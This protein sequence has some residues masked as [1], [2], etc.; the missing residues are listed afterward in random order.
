MQ[1]RVGD[2]IKADLRRNNMYA[3]GTVEAIDNDKKVMHVRLKKLD[4]TSG[5]LMEAP[6]KGDHTINGRAPIEPGVYVQ[7][8]KE[9]DECTNLTEWEKTF[10]GDL[11]HSGH[12]QFSPKQ[13]EWIDKIYQWRV[14][15][16]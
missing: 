16:A 15:D 3:V 12:K 14:T 11:V 13:C 9:L 5:A 4:G 2:E 1:I 7:K 8:L 6:L 10:V